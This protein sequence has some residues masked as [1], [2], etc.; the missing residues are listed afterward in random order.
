MSTL[1]E[2]MSLAIKHYESQTGKR[3]KNTELARFAGVSRANVG[4][5]VNGPTQEL[6]GSNLVKAAEFLGV[7]KDWLAGQSNKMV[8]TPM[9]GSSAQLNVLDIEAFKQKY[10][11]PDNEDAVKFVQTAVKP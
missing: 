6:E 9:D 10:N 7:S 5:W 2:R 3:F 1:Q 8:A 4:L 11:I